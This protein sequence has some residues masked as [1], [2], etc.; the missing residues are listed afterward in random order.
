MQT[1]KNIKKA[2]LKL[3]SRIW[4][5][6][7]NEPVILKTTLAF[8]IAGGYLEFLTDAQ[9]TQVENIVALAV[10]II[11]ALSIRGDVKPLPPKD[12]S[13][14]FRGEISGGKNNAKTD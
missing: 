12:R 1:L 13:K 8:L 10:V 6:V 11:T 2:L 7:Q 3:L 14:I 5:R 4:D 9:V